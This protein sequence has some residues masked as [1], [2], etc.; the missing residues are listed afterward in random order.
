LVTFTGQDA[1][2]LFGLIAAALPEVPVGVV[3]SA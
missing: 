2:G 3:G 1:G